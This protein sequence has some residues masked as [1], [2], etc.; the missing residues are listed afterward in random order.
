MTFTY[1]EDLDTDLSLIRFRVGDTVENAGP[2]PDKRNFSNEEVAAILADENDLTV[3]A[4]ANLFET[5]WSEWA[6]YAVD[7]KEGDVEHD[8][9]EVV[10]KYKAL[11]VEWRAKPGGATEVQQS[12]NLVTLTREDAY[13]E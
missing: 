3:A 1:S 2:R 9:T 5:L 7:E 6:A 11:A 12:G 4:T 10:D 13:T 8:L